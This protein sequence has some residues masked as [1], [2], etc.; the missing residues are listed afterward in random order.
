[1]DPSCSPAPVPLAHSQSQEASTTQWTLKA[2]S[3]IASRFIFTHPQA[4]AHLNKT[5]P[6]KCILYLFRRPTFASVLQIPCMHSHTTPRLR[7]YYMIS[8][9]A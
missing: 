8:A 2:A 1:M 3:L 6:Q 9:L 5:K 7:L 4:S